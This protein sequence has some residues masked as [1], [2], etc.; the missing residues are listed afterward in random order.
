LKLTTAIL[1]DFAQVREGLLHVVSGGITRA[2]RA[3]LP[4]PLS[5]NLAIVVQMDAVE[6]QRPHD[7]LVVVMDEDGGEL[8]KVE[9]QFQ[10]ESGELGVGETTQLPIAFDLR[11]ATVSR[12]G[13]HT[14]GIYVDGHNQENLQLTVLP[15]PQSQH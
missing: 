8:A 1:A 10:L 9:G 6:T 7:F 14:V 3:E 4:G 2:Y 12:Y 11:N 5:I 15:Q 13:S